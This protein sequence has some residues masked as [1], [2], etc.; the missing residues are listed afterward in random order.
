MKDTEM[1]LA[2][3]GTRTTAAV[4]VVAASMEI[5][6]ANRHTKGT[7]GSA[8][9]SAATRVGAA[10]RFTTSIATDVV[11]AT[12]MQEDHTGIPG[13]GKSTAT[14]KPASA[15]TTGTQTKKSSIQR[16]KSGF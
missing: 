16:H 9:V 3:D 10:G 12:L 4:K 8:A 13:S 2:K 15:G 7:G 11:A 5:D 6:A 1:D 14:Q